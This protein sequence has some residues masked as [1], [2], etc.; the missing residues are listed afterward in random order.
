[1]TWV[2]D[3]DAEMPVTVEQTYRTIGDG[4]FFIPLDCTM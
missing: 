4:I 1:M 3:E 2:L